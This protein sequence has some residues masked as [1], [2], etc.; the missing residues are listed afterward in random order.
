MSIAT[1][2][3]LFKIETNL[4]SAEFYVYI[5]S[6]KA[7][8]LYIGMTNNIARRVYEHKNKMNIG[9]TSRYNINSLV[10]FETVAN[11]ISAIKREKQ[12]KGWLREKKIKLIETSNPNWDDLSSSVMEKILGK[13]N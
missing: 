12:L 7:K 5:M 9:F 1:K 3:L 2:N 4:D 10:Y 6:S 11:E 13:Q 8:V